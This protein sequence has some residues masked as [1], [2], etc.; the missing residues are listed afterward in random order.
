MEDSEAPIKKYG[1]SIAALS[2]SLELYKSK[3]AEVKPE[4][5]ALKRKLLNE[6]TKIDK[7]NTEIFDLITL[8]GTQQITIKD[9]MVESRVLNRAINHK[10]N[11][12]KK[13]KNQIQELKQN[14]KELD[15]RLKE[16][17]NIKVELSKP[18]KPSIHSPDY[19]KSLYLAE[20]KR[21][22]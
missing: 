4:L 6:S 12:V 8:T 5:V 10:E 14:V 15:N 19:W 2:K 21:K 9:S 1:K 20:I 13:L 3:W 11:Q 16:N 7:L 18:S 17:E 22:K